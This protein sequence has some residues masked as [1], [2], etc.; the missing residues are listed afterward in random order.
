MGRK[1][2]FAE[3]AFAETSVGLAATDLVRRETAPVVLL[4][5][6]ADAAGLRQ[7]STG[8]HSSPAMVVRSRAVLNL[9]L[10]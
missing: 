6:L 5:E 10:G 9:E 2:T 3:Q 4:I 8:E 1:R 7:S